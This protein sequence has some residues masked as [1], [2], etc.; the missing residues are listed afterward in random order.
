MPYWNKQD[1]QTRRIISVD[2]KIRF[3][4]NVEVTDTCWLWKGSCSRGY[5]QIF[6]DGKVWKVHRY[7]Y[8][9]LVGPIPEGCTIDHV[10]ANGCRNKTCVRPA[11]L[12]PV[13]QLI[14]NRRY[15]ATLTH[16]KRGH[17]YADTLKLRSN[18]KRSCS[19]CNRLRQ[20]LD[21]AG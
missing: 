11:H 10:W 18:G 14:N 13:S 21:F 8:E 6:V 3:W 1:P 5:G 7:A 9:L 2:P 17:L 12:E 20:R 15:H 16:C 4:Y 19:E